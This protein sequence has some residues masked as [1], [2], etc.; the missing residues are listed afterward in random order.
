MTASEISLLFGADFE[1]SSLV[2]IITIMGRGVRVDVFL[3]PIQSDKIYSGR[4]GLLLNS[5]NPDTSN[6]SLIIY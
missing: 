4:A 3:N 2:T 6:K 1:Q 5:V